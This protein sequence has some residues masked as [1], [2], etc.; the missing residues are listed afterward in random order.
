ML[1]PEQLYARRIGGADFGRPGAVYKFGKIKQAKAEA[2]ERRPDTELLDFGVGEPDRMAPAPVR[3]ELKRAVD[4]PENRG[5]ADNGPKPFKQAA[6]DWMRT[7]FG[8]E[9]DP[10]AEVNHCVGLKPALAMLPLAFVNPGDAVLHTVPGYP[11]IATHTRYMGGEPVALP[12]HRDQGFCPDLDAI[13][14]ETA[15]RA[16]LFYVN[17]PNN[18]TGATAT[19]EFFDRL[20]RFADRHGILIVQDAAYATLTYDGAPRSILA[21]PGGKECALEMHSLSKSYN[22]TGWR[23]GF[24]A[25]PSWAVRALAT[26]KDHSD[27]GQFKAIQQ[28]GCAGL[29]DPGLAESI[30]DHYEKRLRRMVELLNVAGF[31]ARMPGGT[32]YLYVPAPK[33]AGKVTFSNA[34][35]AS[36]HLLR[37]HSVSTVP[38]DEAGPYLRFS[39]TFESAGDQDD[40]RVLQ[41]LAARLARAD[42]RF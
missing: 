19:D 33:A 39:A 24:F 23:L 22:M 35:E 31:D 25:G 9:I 27:S 6:A 42:L 36:L 34:E 7:V 1:N 16:K 41:E 13:D 2:R 11:V 5:Y 10:A 32:F 17:Y 29:A 14:P 30:R 20:I 8:A 4:L 12:L 18:P 21:R 38:W 3:E 37:E 40:E 26:V 15:D 28:A